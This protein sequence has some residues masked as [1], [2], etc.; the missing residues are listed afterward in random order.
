MSPRALRWSMICAP[1]PYKKNE[2]IS[3]QLIYLFNGVDGV[4][5]LLVVLIKNNVCMF[6]HV[7]KFPLSH[8]PLTLY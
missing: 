1:V 4:D 3:I 2:C 6:N 5:F 7:L 8:L